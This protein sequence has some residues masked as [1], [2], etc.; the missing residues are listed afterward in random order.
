MKRFIIPLLFFALLGSSATAQPAR[1]IDKLAWLVGGVWTADASKLGGGMQR[2]EVRYEWAPT[3]NFIRFATTFV[4]DQGALVNYAGNIY[5]YGSSGSEML[6]M[7]YMDA[8]GA[9]TQGDVSGPG[10]RWSLT[11]DS[12]G[13]GKTTTFRVDVVK[14]TANEYGWTVSSLEGT[15]KPLFSLDYLRS[16]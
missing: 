15:W 11:F 16:T 6:A 8:K 13:G 3:K 7:W 2:I 4:S 5:S 12:P 1:S 9:I 14:K 10:E